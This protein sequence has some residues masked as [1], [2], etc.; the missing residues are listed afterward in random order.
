MKENDKVS[1][2]K[3]PKFDYSNVTQA[4][5]YIAEEIPFI[6]HVFFMAY[7]D[8]S[9]IFDVDPY[10]QYKGQRGQTKTFFAPFVCSPFRKRISMHQLTIG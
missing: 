8:Q 2:E 5:W 7:V 1:K 3:T 9:Y 4:A 10:H 6:F